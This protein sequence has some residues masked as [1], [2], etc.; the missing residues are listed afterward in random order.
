MNEITNVCFLYVA[1]D[2]ANDT[3]I[4]GDPFKTLFVAR[5]VSVICIV[6]GCINIHFA[7]N[8]VNSLIT[9]EKSPT[10]HTLASELV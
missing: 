7:G 2:P 8:N 9:K 3:T 4:Q 1:G 6:I 10:S 5:I